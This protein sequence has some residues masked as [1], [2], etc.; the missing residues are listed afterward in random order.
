MP[1]MPPYSQ[2]MHDTWKTEV[3]FR[4]WLEDVTGD[5]MKA[6]CKFCKAY[7]NAKHSDLVAHSKTDK[8]VKNS[9]LL[10]PARQPKLVFNQQPVKSLK[11][12]GCLFMLFVT[13]PF[14]AKII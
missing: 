7:L 11:V 9:D 2:K 3:G 8:H 13:V 14:K 12:L 4:D 1:K 5:C 10:S 6:R